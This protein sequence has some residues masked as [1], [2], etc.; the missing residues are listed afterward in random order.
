MH[1]LANGH[2]GV[3]GQLRTETLIFGAGRQ[4]IIAC[5]SLV[6]ASWVSLNDTITYKQ[7]H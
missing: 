2:P 6:L 7:C 5:M 3:V 4:L 1:S